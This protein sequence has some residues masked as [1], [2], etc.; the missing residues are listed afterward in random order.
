ML[1][2]NRK[3]SPIYYAAFVLYMD[4]IMKKKKRKGKSEEERDIALLGLKALA[5]NQVLL[6][7]F[8]LTRL[9]NG[10]GR[11]KLF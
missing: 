10:F 1:I 5:I 7:F 4:I 2:S 11:F 3:P 9:S 6:L 8:V